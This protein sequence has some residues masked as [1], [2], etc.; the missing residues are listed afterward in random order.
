MKKYEKKKNKK[1]MEKPNLA[2]LT[3]W[4]NWG[5]KSVGPA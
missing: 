5:L 3:K 1:A 2:R 4:E